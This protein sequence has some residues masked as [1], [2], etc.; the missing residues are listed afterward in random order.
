MPM[1]ETDQDEQY[2]KNQENTDDIQQ[3]RQ[4]TKSTTIIFT[5]FTFTPGNSLVHHTD[6]GVSSII[7]ELDI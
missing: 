1:R 4:G 6:K 5:L 2:E 3:E 7:V